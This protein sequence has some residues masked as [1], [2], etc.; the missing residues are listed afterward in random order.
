LL[1]NPLSYLG[2]KEVRFHE[3]VLR[4]REASVEVPL[5]SNYRPIEAVAL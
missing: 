1:G 5:M 3:R 2:R 4:G